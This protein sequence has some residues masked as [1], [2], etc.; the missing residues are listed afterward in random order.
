MDNTERSGYSKM[1]RSDKNVNEVQNTVFSD[2]VIRSTRLNYADILAWLC[3]AVSRKRFNFPSTADSS[4]IT[5]LQLT[6]LSST[7]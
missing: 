2:I 5:I 3:E 4:I 7:S 6:I 1:H